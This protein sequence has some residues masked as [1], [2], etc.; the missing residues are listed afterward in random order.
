MPLHWIRI[1]YIMTLCLI[2]APGIPLAFP[3]TTVALMTQYAADKYW[4]LKLGLPPPKVGVRNLVTLPKFIVIIF[5]WLLVAQ[6]IAACMWWQFTTVDF[7]HMTQTITEQAVPFNHAA[8]NITSVTSNAINSTATNITTHDVSISNQDPSF[9]QRSLLAIAPLIAAGMIALYFVEKP[10]ASY[11]VHRYLKA[12]RD[13]GVSETTEDWLDLHDTV[14]RGS[15]GTD[16]GSASEDVTYKNLIERWGKDVTFESVFERW[17]SDASTLDEA[18]ERD[19]ET[20]TV[21]T[22]M[23]CLARLCSYFSVPRANVDIHMSKT[24]HTDKLQRTDIANLE[25]DGS[26]P[27]ELMSHND[28][29]NDVLGMTNIPLSNVG[30][31]ENS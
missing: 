31:D 20:S 16:N 15:L 17:V 30:V 6:C 23:T 2:V 5:T 12:T 4:L 25:D 10:F 13:N 28:D 24:E 8:E 9:L 21:P 22:K 7:V 19:Y 3:T 26:N 1:L 18:P 29:E 11:L 14:Q 27:I